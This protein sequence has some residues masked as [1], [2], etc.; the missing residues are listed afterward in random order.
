[1]RQDFWVVGSLIGVFALCAVV[2]VLLTPMPT[3]QAQSLVA[4]YPSWTCSV[5]GWPRRALRGSRWH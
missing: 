3:V 1:M 4:S 5:D 2:A